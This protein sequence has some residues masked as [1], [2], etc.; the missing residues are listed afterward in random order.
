MANTNTLYYGQVL[1]T[2]KS[3][4]ANNGACFVCMQGNG[5]MC[6]YPS[7]KADSAHCLWAS[8][9][10]HKGFDCLV[11]PNGQLVVRSKSGEAVYTSPGHFPEDIYKLVVEN[12]GDNG[13]LLKQ[14]C[15]CLA[16][17]YQRFTYQVPPPAEVNACS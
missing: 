7:A 3:L 14:G 1:G 9:S 11:T 8:G 16:H 12:D 10:W 6:L 17:Q 13:A 2:D 5:N 15:S 4:T